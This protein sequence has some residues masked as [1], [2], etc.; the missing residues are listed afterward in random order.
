MRRHELTNEQWEKLKDLLPPER[1]PQCGRPAKDNRQMVNAML[2]WLNTGI[3]WRDL[4]ERFGKWQC[5]YARFRNW[6]KQGVWQKVFDSLVMQSLV[7]ETTLLMLDSTTVKV[8]QHGSGVKR[9]TTMKKR[10]E[11]EAD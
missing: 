9:G 10:D 1:K 3:A 11:V 6:S 5:V 2:H 4:P 8:H 7:D